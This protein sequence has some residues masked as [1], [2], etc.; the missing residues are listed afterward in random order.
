[1]NE[2]NLARTVGDEVGRV[3]VFGADAQAATAPASM[4]LVIQ[5]LRI[6]KRRKW[7]LLG[8]IA[9]AAILGIVG[10]ML[11]T[12]L[13]TAS[14]T[15]EIQRENNRIVQ[16]Q[17]AQP[18]VSP[19]DLEFYQTQYGLLQARSLAERVA[20]N[21]RLYD[22]PAFFEMFGDADRATALRSGQ[23]SSGAERQAHID[24]A[25]GILLDNIDIV[26][27]RA[28]R[29]V[30]VRFTSPDPGLSAQVA[31][32][33]TQ[34]FVEMTLAR[35]FEATSYARAFLEQRLEQLRRRLEDSERAL[36]GY[37]RQ[38]RIVNIPSSTTSGESGQSTSERPLVAEDLA[39]LNR[40]LNEATADR[41]AAESRLR[42]AGR[43][44]AEALENQAIS[45]LRSR[46]AELAAEHARML[47]QFEP[48]YP[49]A[50]ALQNQIGELDR[51]IG[52]EEAR[53]R[54]TLQTTYQAAAIREADLRS[55]V[56][57][58][59]DDMLNLRGRTIQYNIYQR[60]V[61][62]NRQLYDA[63]LQRYK[64]IG[65]AGGV[66]VNN[67]SVVDAAEPPGGP[68][69]PRLILNLLLAL[70]VGS[71][72]GAG[73]ALA[74]EQI[75]EA[76]SDPSDVETALGLP[77]LGAVPKSSADPQTELEDRKSALVE[78]YL[79]VQTN[80]GFTT[81]HGFPRSVTVTSTRPGEGKTT[82]SYALARSLGRTG[83]KVLLIDADMR[84]PSLHHI[85]NFKNERGLSNFLSGMDDVASMIHRNLPDGIALMTAG[86]SPPNAAELLMGDRLRKLMQ[87]LTASFDHVI[88]DVPPVMGL[89]DT[90][91][92]ASQ[93][94]G[95]VF[96]I[97]SHATP[98][99]M[100]K[101]AVGR[102]QDAQARVLGVLLTKFESRRAHFGYG[103]DYGYG[104]GEESAK[105]R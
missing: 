13:Y 53:V 76:I 49:P 7:L 98:V 2:I 72:A 54:S 25:A 26:P 105:A 93:V 59:Q 46:R 100:A 95:V 45:S 91:L 97:E 24:A 64:E 65:I 52:R 104:Y 4:P 55:R 23:R 9:I 92:V 96:V 14:A 68:S 83:R 88:L 70:L 43:T 60:E 39:T 78:A 71:A 3:P 85:Y 1:M 41:T 67:I 29:L 103:Y 101:L 81:D 74:M 37:A 73:L 8:A 61:D 82:S 6:A 90:P 10:T 40:S 18:E 80:L 79:S 38:Q 77:L 66:G 84:S 63:L 12:P 35:R 47:T 17:G 56:Q 42:T 75:D 44:P 50:R 86:P 19:T 5:L 16:V 20:T 102:L 33:W 31:N 99:S 36:V 87:E 34:N 62:T 57:R 32:A 58:L 28:S 89:A 48:G 30:D 22:N 15:L 51:A 11:M 94:E 27:T 21:L 69:S